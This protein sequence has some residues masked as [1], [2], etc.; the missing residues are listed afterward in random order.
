MSKN[1]SMPA[2]IFGVDSVKDQTIVDDDRTKIFFGLTVVESFSVLS[3][4]V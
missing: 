1:F 3:N 4:F 2:V